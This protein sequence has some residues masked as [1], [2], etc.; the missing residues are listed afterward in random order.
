[1]DSVFGRTG[2]VVATEGDYTLDLLGDVDVT[3]A[4][5][6]Q[7]LRHDGTSFINEYNDVFFLRVKAREAINKGEVVYIFDAHN[8]NVVGVKKA[9]A[10]S[11]STMPCIGVA[12]QTLALGDE[13][14]VVAFG[15]A[16]G[17]AA[18]FTEGQTMY[19]SPSTA[20]AVTNTKPTGTTHLIQNVGILMQ[21]H[22]TN[23]VV[24]ITGVGRT[25]DIP[26]EFT[27]PGNIEAASLI[28]TGGT[29]SQFVKGDGSL[30]GSTYLT[31]Y[32]ETDP[33]FTAHPAAGITVAGGG[34]VSKG[35]TAF[36][37]GD[38][39]AAGYLTTETD[40]V[41]TAH[42]AAGVTVAGGGD[43]SQGETAFAWGDHAAAGY[44]VPEACAVRLATS[45]VGFPSGAYTLILQPGNW[46]SA[47]PNFN[48]A[49][50]L[51]TVPSTGSY[52]ISWGVSFRYTASGQTQ[53]SRLYVN[54]ANAAQGVA[55][56]T[57]SWPIGNNSLILALNAGDTVSLYAYISASGKNLVGDAVS[58]AATHLNI[59]KVA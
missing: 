16:N 5:E 44:L 59:N 47:N 6:T 1:V 57:G 38:H 2:T 35:E 34:D 19:V 33:V 21:A 43:I 30:D 45:V 17:I 13:G 52:R 14:L 20:G 50:G 27:V 48:T 41:F 8:S 37:W 46:A 7:I 53:T 31:S 15:K 12:Y 28:T 9:R 32:T 25:N 3:S 4:V 36:G 56:A 24:K 42:P 39:G 18:N 10:D 58:L 11:A 23:A 54:G 22:A 26:N 49:T 51:Y 29:S 55:N 40:P